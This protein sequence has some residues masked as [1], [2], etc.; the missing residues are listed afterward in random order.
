M[1]HER[2][3]TAQVRIVADPDALNRAAAGEFVARARRAVQA[4]GR[5]SV[6]L[7]GGS[8]PRGLYALLAGAPYRNR[9]RWERV[10][11]FWT[12]ERCVPS[13][14]PE[15]NFR[16]AHECLLSRVP[17]PDAN[18]HQVQTGRG[19]PAFV[20]RAYE[21]TIRKWFRLPSGAFPEFDLVVLGLGEDGHTASLFPNAKALH[22]TRRL[23]IDTA[24][25]RPNVARVTLSVPVL[26]HAQRLLWLVA[27][28]SKASVVRRVLREPARCDELP[29][30]RVHPSHGTSLW[31]VDREA[32]RLLARP[33]AIMRR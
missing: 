25:G 11:V 2:R 5:F 22:E 3:R 9:I 21:R 14:H 6:A 19:D 1:A 18:I 27:G 10:H 28:A 7:A 23:V 12:D 31:L 29:A 15:S 13:D 30:Q 33:N 26:N 24:G 16:M 20:A 8:T 17:M 4:F 32:A